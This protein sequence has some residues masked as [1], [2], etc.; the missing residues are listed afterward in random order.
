MSYM[1][2]IFNFFAI[3]LAKFENKRKNVRD[4]TLLLER[5]KKS[6]IYKVLIRECLMIKNFNTHTQT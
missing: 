3:F 2:F 1:I 6:L 4:T 5:Q